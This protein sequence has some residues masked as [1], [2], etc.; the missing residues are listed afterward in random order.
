MLYPS[1]NILSVDFRSNIYEH[2]P[3]PSVDRN[4]LLEED[5]AGLL[6]TAGI[7]AKPARQLPQQDRAM[8]CV[9]PVQFLISGLKLLRRTRLDLCLRCCPGSILGMSKA[10]LNC[11]IT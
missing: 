2:T 7:E 10:P 1:A 11:D 3:L 5:R 6:A 9:S 8:L 4:G